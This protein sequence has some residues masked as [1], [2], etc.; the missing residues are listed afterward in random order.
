MIRKSH[1]P[2]NRGGGKQI[3]L[4][5]SFN[6][7]GDDDRLIVS[8]GIAALMD[9]IANWREWPGVASIVT[10]PAKSG[11]S[12]MASRFAALSSG[13]AVDDAETQSAEDL[14]HIWNRAASEN[15]PLLLLSQKLP[16]EWDIAI[17]DIKSR[18]ASA[19]LWH[20]GPPDEEML[21][22]LLHKHAHDQGLHIADDVVHYLARRMERSYQEA[23]FMIEEAGH[24]SSEL[25]KPI[26]L[27][28][29]KQLLQARSEEHQAGLFDG[30]GSD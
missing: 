14:F 25:R 20:I 7:G 4:P 5:L 21:I 29:A 18:I 27:A 13:Y 1:H 24:L 9:H 6:N 19:Q 22:G 26:N 12:R 30:E 16:S 28:M 8:P 17:P 15:K 11:K 10:G 3:A 23:Q 2:V